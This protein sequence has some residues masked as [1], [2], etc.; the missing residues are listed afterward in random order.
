MVQA[1]IGIAVTIWLLAG[2]GSSM[3][4]PTT[5]TDPMVSETQQ[6]MRGGGW[7]RQSLGIC[8][9]QGTG[10]ETRQTSHM[11]NPSDQ[12]RPAAF[13][14]QTGSREADSLSAAWSDSK[15]Y[16]RLTLVLS[17]LLLMVKVPA[18]ATGV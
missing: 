17:P 7:W 6:C 2:C 3:P 10:V 14:R 16:G 18:E 8:D 13:E 11:S 4:A 15:R 1:A 12:A 9:M 5:T